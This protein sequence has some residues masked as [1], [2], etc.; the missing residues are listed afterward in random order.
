MIS[1]DKLPP[2][3]YKI[4]AKE[5]TQVICDTL[6]NPGAG[7]TED[8]VVVEPQVAPP[9]VENNSKTSTP[10]NP[11]E[12]LYKTVDVYP[13]SASASDSLYKTTNNVGGAKRDP[14]REILTL[15]DNFVKRALSDVT[16]KQITDSFAISFTD[17][18]SQNMQVFFGDKYIS[19]YMMKT[20]LD[21]ERVGTNS[22]G[23]TF[24]KML[25]IIT[26]SGVKLYEPTSGD[27]IQSKKTESIMGQLSI[28]PVKKDDANMSGGIGAIGKVFSD[29]AGG[30]GSS[31]GVQSQSAN[32]SNLGKSIG[33]SVSAVTGT[34]GSLVNS[35]LAGPKGP[36]SY[37]TPPAIGPTSKGPTTR[38]NAETNTKSNVPA[39]NYSTL[40]AIAASKLGDKGQGFFTSA[41]KTVFGPVVQKISGEIVEMIEKDLSLK[42]YVPQQISEDIYNLVKEA[43]QF[44]LAKPEGRQMFLRQIEPLLKRYVREYTSSSSDLLT[45]SVLRH[46][47]TTEPMKSLLENTIKKHI[48][49]YNEGNPNDYIESVY[50]TLY[51]A[52]DTKLIEDN[53]IMTMYEK[54]QSMFTSG[55]IGE[56]ILYDY[57]DDDSFYKRTVCT[58]KNDILSKLK[59]SAQTPTI[60]G[61]AGTPPL[62]EKINI[63]EGISYEY[64]NKKPVYDTDGKL[65]YSGTITFPDGRLYKGEW[66][67]EDGNIK[68]HGNGTFHVDSKTTGIQFFKDIKGKIFYKSGAHEPGKNGTD[69]DGTEWQTLE[70]LLKT[71][72]PVNLPS[73]IALSKRRI[74]SELPIINEKPPLIS[75]VEHPVPIPTAEQTQLYNDLIAKYDDIKD[76]NKIPG[77]YDKKEYASGTYYGRLNSNNPKMRHGKGIMIYKDGHLYDG[78]W[79]ADKIH[80]KGSIEPLDN[81]PKLS[82]SF[83]QTD[84]GK[85]YKLTNNGN[86]KQDPIITLSTK[87]G[88]PTHNKKTKRKRRTFRKRNMTQRHL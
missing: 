19:M 14:R 6:Y 45:L 52:I 26:A 81:A 59:I 30:V 7:A 70:D 23:E 15:V 8:V 39:S 38:T 40:G 44:H 72:L 83:D 76:K 50:K 68:I 84:D 63:Y 37:G 71:D 29:A 62:V 5:L 65:I 54:M 55:Q 77:M 16:Q 64:D 4:V 22:R 86:K 47:S 20:L 25:Q 34:V 41:I 31:A 33:G 43:L 82:A 21:E 1:C 32:A 10:E 87:G 42:E 61:D 88:K 60:V 13:E 80:G 66:K 78:V 67:G 69:D 48:D 36:K 27:D 9:T 28:I 49:L 3:F 53:P 57:D 51:S 46:L 18:V 24:K 85:V 17:V 73:P 11:T 35:F 79:K 12:G 75:T 74:H 58:S 2:I 56:K